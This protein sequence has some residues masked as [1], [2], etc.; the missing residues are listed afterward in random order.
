MALASSL[1]LKHIVFIIMRNVTLN[2]IDPMSGLVNF[3]LD[4][5][6]TNLLKCFICINALLEWKNWQY[7]DF[8]LKFIITMNTA[9]DRIEPRSGLINFM[10][11]SFA[12]ER[13]YTM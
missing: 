13:I 6:G 8:L 5:F 4:S 3:K 9:T 10:L 1:L 2:R 12:T 11:D 7:F